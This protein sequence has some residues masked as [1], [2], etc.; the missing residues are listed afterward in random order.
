LAELKL[1]SFDPLRLLALCKFLCNNSRSS[2][3]EAVSR[4]VISRAYY[5]AFLH[6]RE[7]LKE[8]RHV[9]FFGTAEDHKIVENELMNNVNRHLGSTIRTLRENRTASDYD[10]SSPAFPN[11][12][13]R[14]GRR[15][16]N[17]NQVAQKENIR[18]SEYITSNLPSP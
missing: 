17:F 7:Y 15:L 6:T 10:L 3:L 18:L 16:L 12:F 4:T 2:D 8:T 9:Q 5:S 13:S 11:P 1:M 14:F